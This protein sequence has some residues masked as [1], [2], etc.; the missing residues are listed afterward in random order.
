VTDLG[1]VSWS[2]NPSEVSWIGCSIGASIRNIE[3]LS[4]KRGEYLETGFT[5]KIMS[6]YFLS[7]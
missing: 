5:E 2:F 3:N 4:L 1:F 6:T 7:G